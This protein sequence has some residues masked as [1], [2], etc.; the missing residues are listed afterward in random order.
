MI[1][2]SLLS[3]L[4]P[5]P[6]C[7]SYLEGF[8]FVVWFQCICKVVSFLWKLWIF[9]VCFMV[10]HKTCNIS[11]EITPINYLLS[12]MCG[13][14]TEIIGK[15]GSDENTW[16]WTFFLFLQH[17]RQ[18]SVCF[19]Y[20][21]LRKSL[22]FIIWTV[23]FLE[24]RALRTVLRTW[25]TNDPAWFNTQQSTAPWVTSRLA[26][27]VENHRKINGKTNINVWSLCYSCR[28]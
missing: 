27:C 20:L 1:L 13:I 3:F 7:R 9:F 26:S 23:S 8:F 2:I 11:A 4:L 28:M 21:A 16:V 15:G 12:W 25:R 18:L 5:L 17:S 6:I 10:M 19:L 14:W 24:N 22:Y